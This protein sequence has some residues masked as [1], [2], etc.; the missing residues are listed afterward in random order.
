VTLVAI[1][2]LLT[3]YT[4]ADMIMYN[5]KRKAE[6]LEAQQKMTANSLEAARLAYMTGKATE[7]Q[8]ALVE[9][10]NERA[11]SG[12]GIFTKMPSIIGPPGAVEQ[13]DARVWEQTLATSTADEAATAAPWPQ[14]LT[15][16]HAQSE[17]FTSPAKDK[18]TKKGG[19]GSWLFSG[20]AKEEG[21]ND[22]ETSHPRLRSG[23]R[24]DEN[25][26]RPGVRDSAFTHAGHD[27]KDDLRQKA[28]AA[29][30]KEKE[31]QH[32]GAL[33]GDQQPD[34]PSRKGWFW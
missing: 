23:S 2:G 15:A 27:G 4:A 33:E 14:R 31:D 21:G 8:I 5:R 26:N 34:K 17:A 30:G 18:K 20:L 28:R 24:R 25:D 13:A 6:F 3:V 11:A 22:V 9:E 12:G 1:A 29:F 7:E 32:K 19:F 16:E 10:A